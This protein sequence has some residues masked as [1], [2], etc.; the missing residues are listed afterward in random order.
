MN[1]RARWSRNLSYYLKGNA[2][3]MSKSFSTLMELLRAEYR[4]KRTSREKSQD[5]PW[6]RQQKVHVGIQDNLKG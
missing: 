1:P 2:G 3:S 6:Q 5:D 4:A